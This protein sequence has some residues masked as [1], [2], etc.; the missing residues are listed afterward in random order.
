M[1]FAAMQGILRR[2]G[3]ELLRTA[4]ALGFAGVEL[5][6]GRDGL[7]DPVFQE[8]NRQALLAAQRDTGMAIPSICLGVLNDYGYKQ[9]DPAIRRQTTA[10]IH[11]AMELAADVGAKVL[12]IPFFGRSE[13]ETADDLARAAAGLAEVAPAAERAGLALA[14]E[15]FLAVDQVRRL[16]DATGSPAVR[17]YYDVANTSYKGYDPAA[18][19]RALRDV[20][21]QV[22]FK[23]GRESHSE[24]ML[25]QGRVNFPAVVDALRAIGYQGWIV[26][27]SAAPH[28]P[29]AD[30]KANLAF[31]QRLFAR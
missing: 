15:S 23:D 17:V 31:A 11:R 25:G 28:D 26:L 27:E 20:V 7:G 19:L 12:L 4:Q 5:D 29:L 9:A 6:I 22:H 1:Q 24:A 14:V 3:P 8:D 21:A 13:L 10:L 30:A 2:R 16:L 18:E